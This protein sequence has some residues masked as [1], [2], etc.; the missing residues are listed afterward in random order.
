MA[1]ITL[2]TE[3]KKEEIWLI[4]MTKAPTPTEKSKKQ[5]DNTKTPPK[6]SITQRKQTDRTDSSGNDSHRTGAVKPVYRIPTFQL[7]A[8]AV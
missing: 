1:Q 4:P 2:L 7:T 6:T 8:T 3:E 5:S